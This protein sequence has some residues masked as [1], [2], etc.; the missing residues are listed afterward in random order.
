VVLDRAHVQK[1]QQKQKQR[2]WVQSVDTVL[3]LLPGAG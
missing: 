3:P 1:Q 2:N